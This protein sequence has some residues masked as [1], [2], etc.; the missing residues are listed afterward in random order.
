MRFMLEFRNLLSYRGTQLF[1]EWNPWKLLSTIFSWLLSLWYLIYAILEKYKC[2]G[3]NGAWPAD[4]FGFI[5]NKGIAKDG[6]YRAYDGKKGK[7]A[8][9]DANYKISDF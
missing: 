1:G 4:V 7:C 6:E 2:E 3:C 5:K 9:V 8:I